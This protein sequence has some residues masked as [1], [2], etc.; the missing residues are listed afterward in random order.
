MNT[1]ETQ[2]KELS[3]KVGDIIWSMNNE[4]AFGTFSDRI[5]TYANQILDYTTIDYKINIDN[6]VDAYISDSI[7]KKNLILICKETINNAVK[8]SKANL[9]IIECNMKADNIHVNI[10]DNG[11]GFETKNNK[12][13]GLKNMQQRVAE[14][15]GKINII[16]KLNEGTHIEFI[17]PTTNRG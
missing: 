7:M 11:I 13:N 8:Y 2:A 5:K 14:L 6:Q 15:N 9:L 10:K 12:G 1:I 3:E 16:S 4:D 17:I